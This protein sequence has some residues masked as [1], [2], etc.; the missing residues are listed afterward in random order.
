[1]TITGQ[2]KALRKEMLARRAELSGLAKAK[3]D[4]WI[5]QSLWELIETH[6]HKTVHCYLPM[7]REINIFPLIEILLENKI[8]VVTPKTFPNRKLE[9]L[10]LRSLNEL[11]KGVFGTMHPASGEVYVGEYDLIIV[12]GLSFDSENN[13]LGYGGGYY[14]N[15]MVHHPET[16]K[17]GIFYPFQEVEKVPLEPHDVR[18]DDILVDR[19][20]FTENHQEV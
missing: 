17:V 10:L 20:F 19:A 13:R 9:N 12:P 7:R 2:K 8:Q 11:E 5:C 4:Q 15:F 18:L 14:D 16:P 6:A 1:M 3:Y